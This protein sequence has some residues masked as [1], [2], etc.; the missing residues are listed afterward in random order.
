[1]A[2]G[3]VISRVE[4]NGNYSSYTLK[5]NT[6]YEDTK[7]RIGERG[8]PII[9]EIKDIEDEK[10]EPISKRVNCLLARLNKGERLDLEQE[11]AFIDGFIL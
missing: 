4:N 3:I 2:W 1:M 5:Q 8:F 6:F 9:H 11:L 10:V 7:K